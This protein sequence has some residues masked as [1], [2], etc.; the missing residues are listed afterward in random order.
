MVGQFSADEMRERGWN[1]VWMG[2][3]AGMEARL[4]PMR[5]YRMAWIRARALRGK[6]L[7]AKLLLPTNLLL[8][9][10]DSRTETAWGQQV[11]DAVAGFVTNKRGREGGVVN[12]SRAVLYPPAAQSA[13][14]LDA[15]RAAISEA[16]ANAAAELRAACA[17]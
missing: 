5:G 1:V 15:W 16:M 8:A 4:V 11:R 13:P 2:S 6:G 17:N 14:T 3:R 7:L 10:W 12:S 9:F